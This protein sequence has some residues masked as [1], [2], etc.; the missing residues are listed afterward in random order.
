MIASFFSR[1]KKRKL[2]IKTQNAGRLSLRTE[3]FHL[4]FCLISYT[5]TSVADPWHFWYKSGCGSSDPYLWLTD[6]DVD[7]GGLKTY[8]SYRCESGKL[9]HTFTSFFKDNSHK[10]RNSF[11]K[12]ALGVC[13]SHLG[14]F[15]RSRAFFSDS[16]SSE[17]FPDH[18][19]TVRDPDMYL[20]VV[21]NG[22]GC[23]SGR[24]KNIRI[25]IRNTSYNQNIFKD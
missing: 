9:L 24:P 7:P 13:W 5:V 21:T 19:I 11:R 14:R 16:S 22:S 1:V 3:Y 10:D 17:S 18:G 20:W 4:T 12:N 2:T 15:S 25:R 6:P 23:E 8:G